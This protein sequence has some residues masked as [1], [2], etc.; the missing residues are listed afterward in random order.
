MSGDRTVTSKL[1][2]TSGTLDILFVCRV[3]TRQETEQ[4]RQCC[5]P[6]VI[7]FISWMC[8]CWDMPGNRTATSNLLP[9]SDALDILVVWVVTCQETAQQYPNA[10]R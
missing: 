3:E 8:M 7:H 9:T 6:Q 10:T 1:L 2:P 5:Y 4:Q